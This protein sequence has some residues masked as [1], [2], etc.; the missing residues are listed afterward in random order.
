MVKGFFSGGASLSNE[1]PIDIGNPITDPP[2]ITSINP[3]NGSEDGGTV[4]TISGDGFNGTTSVTFGGTPAASFAVDSNSQI[5]ATTPAGSPGSVNVTVT[6]NDGS[7]TLNNGFTYDANPAPNI[8]SISPNN[9]PAGGGT[10]VTIIGTGLNGVSSVTFDG[11]AGT[12]LNVQSAAVLTVETPAGLGSVDV[13]ATNPSGSDTVNGGYTYNAGG[14]FV[15]LGS[16]GL[17]GQFGEPVFSGSGD[18]TPGSAAG[19]TLT[20][21]GA[22]PNSLG[23]LFLGFAPNTPVSPFFG[24]T[25]YPFPFVQYVIVPFDGTGSLVA[26]GTVD[27]GTPPGTSVVMQFFWNDG[28]A[29]QGISGSNGLRI[30]VP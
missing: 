26:P 23:F 14:A 25:F 7:D 24:G 29:I 15:N 19:F 18:L 8:L 21:T 10:T 12:N 11:V 17:A 9:G 28:A 2:D 20:C 22:I 5:T 1:W 4:V 6:D 13:T 27:A 16:S 3:S 30:D